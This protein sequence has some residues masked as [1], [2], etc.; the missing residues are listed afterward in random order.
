MICPAKSL[1]LKPIDDVYDDIGRVIAQHYPSSGIKRLTF[2]SM[3]FIFASV[4]DALTNSMVTW[5]EACLQ[6]MVAE[7]LSRR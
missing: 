4:F 1:D 7:L 2:R 5:C 6:C 3:G